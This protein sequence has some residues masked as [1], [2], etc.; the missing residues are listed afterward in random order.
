MSHNIRYAVYPKNT[1]KSDIIAEIRDEVEHVDWE[2]GGTYSSSQMHWHD[3]K[4][5]DT[6]DAAED[7]IRGYDT[8][9]YS[10][11][12]VLFHDTDGLER[13]TKRQETL[14]SRLQAEKVKKNKYIEEHAIWN[15]KSDTITCPVCKSR[16]NIDSY[17]TSLAHR[18]YAYGYD[19]GHMCPVCFG[20]LWSQTTL[21]T[22]RQYD[23]RIAK[24]EDELAA[25]KQKAKL[26]VAKKSP[27]R[28][29]VKYE[30]HS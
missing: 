16:I 19:N 30:Y 2:E 20:E 25:E 9:W 3:G 10:D 1:K 7:A 5:Y 11:H 4:V 26:K 27:V 13:K 14:E 29:L 17:R 15:R 6:R 22:V 8:G 21:K 12:A 23:E 28:W 24:L 18:R